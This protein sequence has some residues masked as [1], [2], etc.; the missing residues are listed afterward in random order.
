MNPLEIKLEDGFDVKE[1]TEQL[2]NERELLETQHFI[3]ELEPSPLES[4]KRLSK[5]N[6][7]R[8]EALQCPKCPRSFNFTSS[9]KKHVETAHRNDK[10]TPQRRKFQ[11]K[12]REKLLDQPISCPECHRDFLYTTKFNSHMRNVHPARQP[13]VCQF[14]GK[15]YKNQSTFLKHLTTHE[16][17][18]S[19]K[20]VCDICSKRFT[21]KFNLMRHKIVSWF[22]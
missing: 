15:T 13:K 17:Y 4:K 18:N 12:P 11:G 9:L 8:I 10:L 22:V 21:D 16:D 19:R 3:S 2:D 5:T 1:E 20:L 6:K 14:C 7:P